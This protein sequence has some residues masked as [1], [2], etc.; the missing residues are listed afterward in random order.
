VVAFGQG[1]NGEIYAVTFDTPSIYKI[2]EH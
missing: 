2:V 1:R